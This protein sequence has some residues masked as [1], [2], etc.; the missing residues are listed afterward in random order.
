MLSEL[1]N[2][3][4]IQNIFCLK[5]ILQLSQN[6]ILHA[7]SSMTSISWSNVQFCVDLFAHVTL[8]GQRKLVHVLLHISLLFPV[9]DLN[10]HSN[11]PCVFV[12]GSK[13]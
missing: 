2:Q 11:D 6:I 8:R 3:E 5:T 13:L 9:K 12:M 1:G 4:N 10:L 7:Y